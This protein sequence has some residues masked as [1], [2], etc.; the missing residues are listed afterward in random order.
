MPPSFSGPAVPCSGV[1][2]VLA[3][4]EDGL[5]VCR[6]Y[7]RSGIQIGPICLER[8]IGHQGDQRIPLRSAGKQQV[9]S[10][11]ASSPMVLTFWSC[12]G[13]SQSYFEGYFEAQLSWGG[14]LNIMGRWWGTWGGG[15]RKLALDCLCSCPRASFFV[16]F[17]F[18]FKYS[19]SQV[20]N[21]ILE[22]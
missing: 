8:C 15:Q 12:F 20:S 2:G 6:W 5:V 18:V 9:C 14:C 16:L 10:D 11:L 3:C 21:F 1:L 17:C 22:F 4:V 19:K 13:A 7:F